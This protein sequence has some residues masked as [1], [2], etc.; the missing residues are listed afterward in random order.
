[1]RIGQGTSGT[2]NA[3]ESCCTTVLVYSYKILKAMLCILS[4]LVQN[5]ETI[6]LQSIG[7]EKYKTWFISYSFS[8]I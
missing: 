1:M 2:K 8:K 6:V 3:P 5:G 7:I 4:I